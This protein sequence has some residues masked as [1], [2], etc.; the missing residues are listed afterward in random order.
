VDLVVRPSTRLDLAE[1][2]DL[3]RIDLAIGIFSQVPVAPELTH[4]AGAG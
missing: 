4:A 3:G 2:I 1:Q